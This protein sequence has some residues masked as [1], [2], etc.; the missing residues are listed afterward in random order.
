MT[1]PHTSYLVCGT[2]RCGS[3]LFCEALMNTGM[4]GRP[5]E[6]FLPSNEALWRERWGSVTSKNYL[7][8]VMQ[9]GTTPNGV[10]GAK[11]MW[12]YFDHFVSSLQQLPE[13]KKR[14]RAAHD[15]MKRTFPNLHYIWIKRRDKVRQAI[16]HAK[17]RQTNVW[18][19][20]S[21]TR[22]LL[23][24]KPVFSFE[25]IDL[26]VQELEAQ[27]A[28]WKNYFLENGIDPFVVVYEDLAA[29]YE[30]VALEALRYLGVAHEPVKFAPSR[31]KKQADEESEVWVQRYL[32]LKSKSIPHR[33]LSYANGRLV[34]FLQTTT[35][36]RSL[37]E[38][39][40]LANCTRFGYN[41]GGGTIY[42]YH[43][44]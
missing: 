1:Q 30:E 32:Y 13:Q 20:T 6:Y 41:K 4:A 26:M 39:R 34:T 37:Y 23:T 25:Q 12:G 17:A 2:P 36:G 16:S 35:V 27:E 9:Q 7:A 11:I 42:E 24:K 33:L 5:E 19:V 44:Q 28:A 21:E 8:A 43:L 31:M 15:L 22:P 38:M 14:E 40:T 3:T 18:A 10:F 29:R